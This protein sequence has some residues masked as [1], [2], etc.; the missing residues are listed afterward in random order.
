MQILVDT[1]RQNPEI[2]LFLAL[3]IGFWIGGVK[4]GSFSLGA[5]T[6]TLIAG[7]LIGQLHITFPAV[8]QNIF[9]VIF[10]FAVG[11]DVGPQFI[12]AMKKDG[13]PQLL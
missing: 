6:S 10:L 3:A 1:L 5:V 12:P 4:F 2:A 9:F 7:L 8:V 13:L 11:Y